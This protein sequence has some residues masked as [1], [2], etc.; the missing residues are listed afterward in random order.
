MKVPDTDLTPKAAR[1]EN[2]IAVGVKGNAP[3][4]SGVTSQSSD[5]SFGSQISNIDI[6]I[7]MRRSHFRAE[8][9]KREISF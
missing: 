9:R 6:M 7:T 5:A 1:C 2:I 8:Y 4:S 3:R